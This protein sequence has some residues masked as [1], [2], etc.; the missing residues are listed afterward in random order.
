MA[1]EEE[2]VVGVSLGVESKGDLF[3]RTDERV[4][5]LSGSERGSSVEEIVREETNDRRVLD[6]STEAENRGFVRRRDRFIVREVDVSRIDGQLE[7]HFEN[8][9]GQKCPRGHNI[10]EFV[11]DLISVDAARRDDVGER[12]VNRRGGEAR[13]SEEWSRKQFW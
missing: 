9:L 11:I 7:G 13:L 5:F 12:K 4:G 3:R 10:L 1:G 8:K 6:S 2:V